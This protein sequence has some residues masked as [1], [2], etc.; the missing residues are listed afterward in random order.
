MRLKT[1]ALVQHGSTRL[2]LNSNISVK[3]YFSVF[4][5]MEC[6]ANNNYIHAIDIYDFM[7]FSKHP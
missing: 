7:K 2:D 4:E 5:V 3:P 1:L 6:L